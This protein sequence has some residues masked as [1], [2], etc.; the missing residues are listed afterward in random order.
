MG[1]QDSGVPEGDSN[2]PVNEIIQGNCIDILKTFPSASVDL[3]FADPPYNLQLRRPLMRP[4]QSLVDAVDDEWDQFSTFEDYDGFTRQWLGE[5]QRV[6]KDHGAI[7]VIGSYHNIFRVGATMLDLGFWILNDVIWHKTNPMPNFLGTRF[8]NATETL[9]WAK[10]SDTRSGYTFNYHAMKHL[11]DEKQMSNVWHIPLCTGPERIKVNG[12]K[13][14]STQKPEALLYRVLLASSNPG[15]LV[16]DPF[17]GTGTTGAV[18]RKLHRRF[19]GIEY[20][21]EY[22]DVARARIAALDNPPADKRLLITRSKR[23]APKVRFGQLIEAGYLRVGQ[24]IF[25]RDRSARATIKADSHLRWGEQNGSIHRIAA[26]AQGK[27]AF[28]GWEFW[29]YEDDQGA[30]HSI[31]Q[32]RERYRDEHSPGLEA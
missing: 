12:K 5:C 14:H 24:Q 7:W 9:I 28:N 2:L 16:L 10:K 8:Q 15:D 17:F 13:A 20:E 31:D 22:I 1:Q 30:L 25:S 29:F 11:N 18:A 4:D 6:L 3:I 21:Q 26:L 27:A 32:L 23:N 19:I